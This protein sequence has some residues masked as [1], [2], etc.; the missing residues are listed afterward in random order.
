[1]L[2]KN[3]YHANNQIAINFLLVDHNQNCMY[4]DFNYPFGGH[5][6]H[7]NLYGIKLCM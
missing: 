4:S 7:D 5:K 3:F 1:M 6:L 2:A